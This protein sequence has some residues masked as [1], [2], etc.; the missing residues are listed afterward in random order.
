[1]SE[2]SEQESSLEVLESERQKSLGA[3][4]GVFG[5]LLFLAVVGAIVGMSLS[6]QASELEQVKMAGGLVGAAGLILAIGLILIF[7]F[8]LRWQSFRTLM[9]VL[10]VFIVFGV[11]AATIGVLRKTRPEAAKS[12][13]VEALVPRVEVAVAEL[14]EKE[15]TITGEG[16]VES[17]RVVSLMAEVVGKLVEVNPSLVPGGRVREGEILVRIEASDYRAILEQSKAA[18]ERAKMAVADAELA[19]EQEEARRKQALRDWAKLGK[20]EPSDLLARKPQIASVQASLASARAEVVSA[21]AEIKRAALNLERTVIRAPFDSVVRR[22]S[23]EVGAVVGQGSEIA[24]LFSER[25][26]EVQLPLKLADYALLQRDGN[27]QVVGEVQLTGKLGERVVIWPGRVLRTSGEVERGALTAGVVIAVEPADGEGELRFP[28]TGLFLEA[29]LK[30]QALS[31]AVQI[32]REAVRDGS[33]AAIVGT[34][35]LLEFRDLEVVRAT[36]MSVIVQSGVKA[37]EQVILTRLSGATAGMKVQVGSEP[38]EEASQ[39]EAE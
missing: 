13:E 29:K 15:V 21:E 11:T 35:G 23:V 28:P 26:L 31:G 9:S 24:T 2:T 37:G 16:V 10:M 38:N 7:H 22:E 6:L 30:G 32:P 19:L 27:G 34:D 14:F 25:N 18:K 3:I 33:R 39:E 4:G 20:G 36:R 1:M 8:A 17:Q 5:V 12:E